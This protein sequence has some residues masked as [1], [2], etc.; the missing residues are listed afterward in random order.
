MKPK[1]KPAKKAKR[2]KPLPLDL[3][4]ILDMPR[5]RRPVVDRGG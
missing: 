4:K 5:K 3:D 2:V 1:P